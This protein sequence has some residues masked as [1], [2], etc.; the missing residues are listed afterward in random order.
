MII[1]KEEALALFFTY[2]IE[3]VYI[4]LE[5]DHKPL[6]GQTN[7][8]RLQPCVLHF[9]IHLMCLDCS[10]HQPRIPSKSLHTKPVHCHAGRFLTQ[11]FAHQRGPTD[12]ELWWQHCLLFASRP[13]L[14]TKVMWW[15]T[16]KWHLCSCVIT[17]YARRAGLTR[18]R[19]L[20]KCSHIGMWETRTHPLQWATTL[21]G[22]MYCYSSQPS[23]K[24][25]G[26]D[27]QCPSRHSAMISVDYICLMMLSMK[28]ASWAEFP[29]CTKAIA[30]HNNSPCSPQSFQSPM[31][32]SRHWPD[33]A[34]SHTRG[35]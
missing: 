35:K 16:A 11:W 26:D 18:N 13:R 31:C 20:W 29:T 27:P 30:C 6:M 32:E 33:T 9:R 14:P 15:P 22:G 24:N 1:E 19:C 34:L 7:L 3:K 17:L 5:T 10:M 28:R 23:E 21:H 4:M 25:P 12:G 8:D 2:V